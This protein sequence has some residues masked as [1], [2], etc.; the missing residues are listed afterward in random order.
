[1]EPNRNE[2]EMRELAKAT[3]ASEYV[4]TKIEVPE[5]KKEGEATA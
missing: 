5:E 1:M 2:N 4:Y 3:Q